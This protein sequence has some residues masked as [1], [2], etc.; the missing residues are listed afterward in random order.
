MITTSV[1]CC[2][3]NCSSLGRLPKLLHQS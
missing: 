2:C 1:T 3:V